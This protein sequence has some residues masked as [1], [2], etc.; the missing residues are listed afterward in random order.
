MVSSI[1]KNQSNKTQ[2][3][4]VSELADIK[5]YETRSLDYQCWLA[6]NKD[7]AAAAQKIRELMQ[8]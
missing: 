4:F 5:V 1:S 7:L 6:H 8:K 2:K 3:M